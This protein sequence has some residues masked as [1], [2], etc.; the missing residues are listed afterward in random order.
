VTV[1]LET[2]ERLLAAGE[3]LFA[4]RGFRKVTVREICTLARAN[5]AAVNYYF[6]DKLGLYR[7]VLQA[8]I[9]TMRQTTEMAR[10]EGEGQPPEEQLRRFIRV[11]IHRVLTP[12]H[13][14]IQR[15]IHRELHDPTPA[16]EAIV[17]QA[18]RPRNEY[19]SGI[20][21]RMI[22]CHPSDEPVLRSVASIQAQAF[23]YRP[24]PLLPGQRDVAAKLGFV[25]D[26]TPANIAAAAEHIATFS[27]AGVYAISRLPRRAADG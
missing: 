1:D 20:I 18:I 7:E 11:F 22:G 10:A 19:L 27:I 4:E 3:Q 5:V 14:S 21:A 24:H 9:D 25:F 17:E 2:R 6:G 26:P 23:S 13:E 8:T 15:L 12:G 16:L